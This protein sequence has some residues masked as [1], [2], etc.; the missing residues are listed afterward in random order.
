[1]KN[2]P[3]EEKYKGEAQ[4]KAVR[5]YFAD[6]QKEYDRYG[7]KPLAYIFEKGDT[8]TK[9]VDQVLTASP[10]IK[11]M[12]VNELKS[13]YSELLPLFKQRDKARK[14]MGMEPT[15]RDSSKVKKS[16]DSIKE[17]DKLKYRGYVRSDPIGK[18]KVQRDYG[19][20]YKDTINKATE[21]L[22]DGGTP[23]KNDPPV[24]STPSEVADD[25]PAMISE[26][27]FV[28]P[29]DVVRYIGLDKIR[30]IMHQAKHGLACMEDEGLIVDVDEE[31]RPQSDQK[32]K[33]DDNV[34]IIETVQIEKV[35]PMMTQM[36]EG[37]MT[38]KDSPVTSPILNPENKPVMNQGG[39]VIAP[40]GSLR[41]AEGGMPM[42][43]DQMMM[44][45]M[46]SE[47]PEMAMPPELSDEMAPQESE[48]MPEAPMMNAPVAQEFNGVP[49]LMAYLQEDEIKALQEAGRGLDENGEQ[50]LSPEGIPVFISGPDDVNESGDIGGNSP[51]DGVGGNPN[52]Q[53]DDTGPAGPDA[54]VGDPGSDSENQTEE[55][56]EL[57]KEVKEELSPEKKDKTYVAGVGFIDKYIE[58]RNSR[59]NP[60]QGKPAYAVATV[61]QGGLMRTPL[62]LNEGGMM[63]DDNNFGEPNQDVE[64]NEGT[65]EESGES[66]S[67]PVASVASAEVA[68]ES[69]VASEA[70]AVE[71]PVSSPTSKGLMQPDGT[72]TGENSSVEG[73][74]NSLS[75]I[76]GIN[77]PTIDYL[78]NNF[79][80]ADSIIG[81]EATGGAEIDGASIN[82]GALKHFNEFGKN[83]ERVGSG[84]FESFFSRPDLEEDNIMQDTMTDESRAK[85]DE[86]N[87][88][89]PVTDD[90][91][92]TEGDGEAIGEVKYS[93]NMFDEHGDIQ[94]AGE[95]AM[96]VPKGGYTANNPAPDPNLG[97]K[98]AI[99]AE[100]EG[101]TGFFT[102][103]QVQYFKDIVQN[104]DYFNQDPNYA[105]ADNF[106]D[107]WEHKGGNTFDLKPGTPIASAFSR[108]SGDGMWRDIN[109]NPTTIENAVYQRGGKKGQPL[110][111]RDI[112][113]AGT[114]GMK[115]L[116]NQ[117]EPS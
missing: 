57:S 82:A 47:E 56:K 48:P 94:N 81:D 79:D 5:K 39:M 109:N 103:E 102:R 74:R 101:G 41:M 84:G 70:V 37:G 60:L 33:S 112:I 61:A 105:E 53:S 98:N 66:P 6:V 21:G 26:G 114:N 76:E 115:G 35:D 15:L 23:M 68:A 69:P 2:D 1:M 71:D 58:Q 16:L 25:I 77:Q 44:E 34:A 13:D 45:E 11:K 73:L 107:Y 104:Q 62:Y 67:S 4:A 108:G 90:S 100:K 86:F 52:D 113:Y 63:D 91:S 59:P 46:P 38:D 12:Y 85:I 10:E 88:A 55:F 8:I 116:A 36:A 14:E 9:M 51:T 111:V 93:S 3:P 30:E 83:E 24:G 32:E 43:M 20:K 27:E 110:S 29:A 89:N 72:I 78:S 50:I 7:G 18:I 117:Y 95:N 80:V 42:Q 28:I 87:R 97:F 64:V 49:H 54:D 22:K 17:S 106:D 40:D 92:N 31:G 96:S 65:G 19:K 75:Q 99:S